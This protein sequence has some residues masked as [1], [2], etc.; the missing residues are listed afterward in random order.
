MK[1]AIVMVVGARASTDHKS[2]LTGQ[3]ENVGL[4]VNVFSNSLNRHPARLLLRFS[5]KHK[6][7][8]ANAVLTK[9]RGDASGRAATI[10]TL[11]EVGE[12]SVPISTPRESTCSRSSDLVPEA[13]EIQFV[14][15][16]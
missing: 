16:V 11:F 15:P 7:I 12:R 14:P 4:N 9:T 13:G 6:N 8:A 10:C 5:T 2:V 1:S 3:M